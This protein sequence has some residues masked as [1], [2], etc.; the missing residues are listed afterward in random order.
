[1]YVYAEVCFNKIMIDSECSVLVV[2]FI[3]AILAV[4]LRRDLF[5][6]VFGEIG[7]LRRAKILVKPIGSL[8]AP[9][10]TDALHEFGQVG[11]ELGIFLLILLSHL[12]PLFNSVEDSVVLDYS[13]KG[14]LQAILAYTHPA[15][16]FSSPLI[17]FKES[18]LS[19]FVHFTVL[20]LVVVMAVVTTTTASLNSI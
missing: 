17:H 6:K 12:G 18:F 2:I 5:R 19:Y 14:L 11:I 7:S 10:R 13:F 4:S 8:L 15:N 16:L 1:M 20:M 3:I 9:G